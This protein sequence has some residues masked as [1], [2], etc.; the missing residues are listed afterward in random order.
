M[1]FILRCALE[2]NKSGLAIDVMRAM[3]E[4]GLPLRPHYCWPLLVG[5]QKEK[6]LKGVFEVLKVMHELGVELNAETYTDYV[7]KNFADI[8]T[9]C[10]QMKENNCL[11]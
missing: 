10:A 6:N 4:E 1:I 9:A 2:T 3:K 8:E 5:F 11:L 7:F